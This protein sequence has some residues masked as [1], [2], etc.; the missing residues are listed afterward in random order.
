MTTFLTAFATAFE[1]LRVAFLVA[2]VLLTVV[3]LID[4]AVRTRRLSPFGPV[5]R[6][7]RST[8]DPLIAPVERRVVRAGGVPTSAPWWAL[9]A[10]VVIGILVLSALQFIGTQ[11]AQTITA[12][13]IGPRAIVKLVVHWAFSLVQIAIVVRVIASWLG[14]PSY[15]WWYRA[16]FWLSEWLLAPL[17]RVIPTLGPIDIS[18]IAAFILIGLFESLVVGLW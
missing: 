8:V 1:Y 12:A 5:A 17:R 3:V 14:G 7:F 15:R 13:A 6:F 18:P 11:I 16:A 10:V 9:A 2:A 4:W